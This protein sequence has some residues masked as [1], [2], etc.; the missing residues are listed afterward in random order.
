MYAAA[1]YNAECLLISTI[2]HQEESS[3]YLSL[4][5][6]PNTKEA[7]AGIQ[8][9]DHPVYIYWD[10][11][12]KENQQVTALTL[13][14]LLDDDNT[15]FAYNNVEENNMYKPPFWCLLEL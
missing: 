11:T 9:E 10:S 14:G 5:N 2:K 12:S 7:E 8:I 6:S 3:K 4:A 13:K 1:I 15:V